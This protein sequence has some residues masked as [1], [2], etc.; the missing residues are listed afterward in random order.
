MAFANKTKQDRSLRVQGLAEQIAEHLALKIIRGE[1]KAGERLKELEL[2]KELQVA[3]N[4]L[5][6]AIR[7]LAQTHLVEIA[8]RRT[9]QVSQV[10]IDSVNQLY[11]FLFLQL[12]QLA[13]DASRAWEDDDLQQFTALVMRMG[14]HFQ[15]DDRESFHA[16]AF[17]FIELGLGFTDN[18]FLRSTIEQYTPLLRRYSYLA[19]Q[20]EAEELE[21]SMQIFQSLMQHLIARE[22]KKAAKAIKLYGEHQRQMITAALQERS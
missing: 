16:S 5:R 18:Q 20:L 9:T 21:I 1:L 8:P 14:Q 10:D 7:L 6:E 13:V 22:G 12:A 11:G 3:S 17:E 19:L 4:T 15:S 2:A